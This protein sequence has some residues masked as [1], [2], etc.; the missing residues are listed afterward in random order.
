MERLIAAAEQTIRR[1]AL[2]DAGDHV[3]VAVSG[4]ADSVCLLHVLLALQARWRLRLSVGHLDHGL[5]GAQSAA[6]ARFVSDLCARL[7]VPCMTERRVVCAGGGGLQESARQVRYAF[8]QECADRVDARR[9]AL[10]HHADDQ[11][12]TVLMWLVRGAGGRGLAGMPPAR[13]GRFVRPLLDCRRAAIESFLRAGKIPFVADTSAGELYYLRNRIRHQV[14]PLLAQDNPRVVEALCRG[15]E[16]L[17]ED[18]AVLERVVARRV[19][20]QLRQDACSVALPLSVFRAC[21]P[22]LRPRLVRHLFGQLRHQLRGLSAERVRAVVRLC[23]ADGPARMVQLPGGVQ[24][25]REYGLLVLT[26][27]AP[28]Q[29]F[30]YHFDQ[31]PHEVPLPEIGCVLHAAE[32]AAACPGDGQVLDADR[33]VAPLCVR[34]WRPGDRF[35]PPGMAGR[36]KIK[37]VFSEARIPV[38]DRSRVPLLESNGTILWAGGLQVGAAAQV[39]PDSRRFVRLWLTGP[40]DRLPAA[41]RCHVGTRRLDC[42]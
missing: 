15:A 20:G 12:E 14:M 38:R 25:W 23:A 9:I 22:E 21:E 33:L 7:Q 34:S 41:G 10:G 37:R 42:C 31:L 29:P 8:L 1:D 28:A 5:R 13:Q 30:C 19:A 4:G 39:R 16:A 6:E 2:L 35:Q 11:A 40:D 32:V 26:T 3:L 18:N 24:V 36:K 17:R 27:A